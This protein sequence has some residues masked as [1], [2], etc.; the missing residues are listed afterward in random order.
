MP[1]WNCSNLL[2]VPKSSTLHHEFR[3]TPIILRNLDDEVPEVE[4]FLV[5][6]VHFLKSEYNQLIILAFPFLHRCT[7][8]KNL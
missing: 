7:R 1:R 5:D 6:L 2:R 4:Y 8:T 3:V